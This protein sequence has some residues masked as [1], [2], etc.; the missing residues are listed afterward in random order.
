MCITT[1]PASHDAAT[2]TISGSRKPVTSLIMLAPASTHALATDAWRVS[3]LTHMSSSAKRRTTSKTRLSSSSSET[4]SAPGRMDSPPTSTIRAPSSIIWRPAATASSIEA[5][6]PPSEKES[7]VT[8]SIPII[9]G[10]L[11][12][13]E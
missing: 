6:D 1:R 9:T 12:S 4:G 7:G 11:E 3:M 10:V 5:Y 13:N 2:L 8:F